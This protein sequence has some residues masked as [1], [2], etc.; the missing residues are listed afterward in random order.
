M[1]EVRSLFDW[2]A[3]ARSR[4]GMFVRGHSLAELESQCTGWEAALAAHSIADPGTGFNA[5]FRDWLRTTR[6]W[7]VS[8]GW[9]EAI[10]AH[11]ATEEQA[12]G[13]FFDLLDE[14]AAG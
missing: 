3:E 5:R 14:F 4:P 13:M 10:R 2:L 11:T 7:S 1:S 8:R 6:G 9:A 12:W